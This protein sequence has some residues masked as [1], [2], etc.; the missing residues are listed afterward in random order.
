MIYLF[1]SGRYRIYKIMG[2]I[3]MSLNVKRQQI[4]K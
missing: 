2:N 3:G 4:I 1:E